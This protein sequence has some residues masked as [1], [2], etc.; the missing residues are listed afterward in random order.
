MIH[1]SLIPILLSQFE[2]IKFEVAKNTESLQ[3]SKSELTDLRRKKQLLEIDVQAMS[4]TVCSHGQDHL[5]CYY[6]LQNSKLFPY[7]KL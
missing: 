7:F 3:S 4:T 5:L 6:C 1:C 2:N